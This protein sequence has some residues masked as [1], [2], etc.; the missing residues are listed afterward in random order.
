MCCIQDQGHQLHS[1][2]SR[3]RFAARQFPSLTP[4]YLSGA[5]GHH[6]SGYLAV[7]IASIQ[8]HLE[9]SFYE[10]LHHHF[11]RVYHLRGQDDTADI[12]RSSMH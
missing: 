12:A 9:A 5:S 8:V 4:S 2:Q 7:V 6:K 1:P 3:Q 10:Q 11:D